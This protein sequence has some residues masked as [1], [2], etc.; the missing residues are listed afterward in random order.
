MERDYFLVSF[1]SSTDV[2]MVM[3]KGPWLIGVHYLHIQCWTNTFDAKVDKVQ[4]MT[5]WARLPG[6]PVHHYNKFF[7]RRIVQ[8][9]GKVDIDHQTAAKTRG[10]FARLAVEVDLTLSIVAE[11]VISPENAPLQWN[12]QWHDRSSKGMNKNSRAGWGR[13]PEQ[14]RKREG[15]CLESGCTQPKQEGTGPARNFQRTRG[16]STGFLEGSRFSMLSRLQE[17]GIESQKRKTT[18]LGVSDGGDKQ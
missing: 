4:F 7:L 1:V 18:N 5:V 6:I 11:L 8:L 2:E 15:S 12:P 17:E 3:T 16:E 13:A 10:K 9:V 14:R